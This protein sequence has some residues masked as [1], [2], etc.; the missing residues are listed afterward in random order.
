MNRSAWQVRGDRLQVQKE[1]NTLS[2]LSDAIPSDESS[3]SGHSTYSDDHRGPTGLVQFSEVTE[4][5]LEMG[6]R[7][8]LSFQFSDDISEPRMKPGQTWQ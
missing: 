2:F 4:Q 3:R 8:E 6:N 5:G 7:R 1:H